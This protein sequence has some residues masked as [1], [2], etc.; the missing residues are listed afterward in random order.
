MTDEELRIEVDA[1]VRRQLAPKRP[2]PVEKIDPAKL[3]KSLENLRRPTVE[4]KLHRSIMKSRESQVQRACA[5]GRKVPQGK[6]TSQDRPSCP[7][8]VTYDDIK[9]MPRVHHTKVND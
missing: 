3:K 9:D 8:K 4:E 6:K 5:S 2:E 1:D 7:Q